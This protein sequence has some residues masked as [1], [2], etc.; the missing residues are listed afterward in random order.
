MSIQTS[1]IHAFQTTPVTASA[2]WQGPD[3]RWQL[4]TPVPVSQTPPVRAAQGDHRGT[5][6]A[7]CRPPGSPS[8]AQPPHTAQSRFL[9]DCPPS[10]AAKISNKNTPGPAPW[11]PSGVTGHK[12]GTSPGS[13]PRAGA[14]GAPHGAPLLPLPLPATPRSPAG[15]QRDPSPPLPALPAADARRP[16]GVHGAPEPRQPPPA[17]PGPCPVP[18]AGRSRRRRRKP[19]TA[20]EGG[21]EGG[22]GPPAAPARAA[23]AANGRGAEGSGGSTPPPRHKGVLRQPES[24]GPARSDA[25]ALIDDC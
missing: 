6:P 18:I 22:A 9:T 24:R 16:P 20:A 8:S 2:F 11:P 5:V 19:R 23:M 7:G 14:Q 17:Q 3:L 1:Q 4:G 12:P 10:H 21:P 13:A 15:P 25:L